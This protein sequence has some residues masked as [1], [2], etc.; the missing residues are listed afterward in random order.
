[1]PSW[2]YDSG[3]LQRAAWLACALFLAALPGCHSPTE[4]GTGSAFAPRSATID[5]ATVTLEAIANRDEQPGPQPD[6]SLTIVLRLHTSSASVRSALDVQSVTVVSNVAGEHWSPATVERHGI[7][8]YPGDD[9][10]V[11]AVRHGP[12]WPVGSSCSV[13]ATVRGTGGGAVMGD[14]GVVIGGTS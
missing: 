7:S 12:L 14:S 1:M 5:G 4:P 8:P 11:F 2:Q 10:T 9:F 6:S 13:T 3:M